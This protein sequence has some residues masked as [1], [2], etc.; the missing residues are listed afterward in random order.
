MS[1]A[2]KYLPGI[3]SD[4]PVCRKHFLRN[5]SVLYIDH[6]VDLCC[7]IFPVSGSRF[8]RISFLLEED[9]MQRNEKNMQ[10]KE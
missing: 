1:T 7:L 9:I 2:C 4:E 6:M 3:A 5:S 10:T 8:N